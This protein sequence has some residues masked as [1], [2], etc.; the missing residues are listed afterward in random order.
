[1]AKNDDD[2]RRFFDP[3]P[4][5]DFDPTDDYADRLGITFVPVNYFDEVQGDEWVAI[6]APGAAWKRGWLDHAIERASDPESKGPA[7]LLRESRTRTSWGADGSGVE[8]LAHVGSTLYEAAV[9]YGVGKLLEEMGRRLAER[10]RGSDVE[11]LTISEEEAEDAAR[12]RLATRYEVRSDDFS[13]ESI[14]T[15]GSTATMRLLHRE[16]GAEYEVTVQKGRGGTHLVRCKR[17][18]PPTP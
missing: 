3:T 5:Y 1:M 13:L 6:Q 14:E 10:W 9:A 18:G 16:T 2:A 15:E 12:W 4:E 8:Y 7:L 11:D 17:S